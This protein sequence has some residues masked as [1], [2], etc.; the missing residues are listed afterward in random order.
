MKRSGPGAEGLAKDGARALGT[1]RGGWGSCLQS[2]RRLGPKGWWGWSLRRPSPV[3]GP[4]DRRGKGAGLRLGARLA[5]AHS[6]GSGYWRRRRP[7]P[8]CPAS[9][10]AWSGNSSHLPPPVQVFVRPP[11]EGPV[12]DLWLSPVSQEHFT[13]EE[14]DALPAPLSTGTA[15]GRACFTTGDPVDCSPRL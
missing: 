14:T 12:P 4:A 5:P 8:S 15:P 6:R 13:G 10:L 7:L 11:G 1:P 2:P 3:T 9:A